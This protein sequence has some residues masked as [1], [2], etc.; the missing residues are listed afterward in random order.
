MYVCMCV[1]M[2]LERLDDFKASRALETY[3][4]AT[5]TQ[6]PRD[7]FQCLCEALA[8][9]KRLQAETNSCQRLERLE[10]LPVKAIPSL[11][12]SFQYVRKGCLITV[13]VTIPMYMRVCVMHVC[14]CVCM[15]VFTYVCMYA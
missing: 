10:E 15:Y 4:L 14:M 7:P 11:S 2:Y 13:Y 5:M 8:A 12:R 6:K 3:P 1:C 9:S